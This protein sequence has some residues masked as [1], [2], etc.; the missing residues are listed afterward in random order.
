MTRLSLLHLC[1]SA[2][3]SR[4]KS[5]NE[6]ALKTKRVEKGKDEP[7]RLSGTI[8]NRTSGVGAL[9]CGVR[10][11]WLKCCVLSSIQS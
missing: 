3:G 8:V 7:G 2:L 6:R 4:G 11:K 5:C 10:E 1:S 9:V